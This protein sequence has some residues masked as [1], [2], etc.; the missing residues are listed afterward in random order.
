MAWENRKLGFFSNFCICLRTRLYILY[1]APNTYRQFKRRMDVQ[2]DVHY[3]LVGYMKQK[4]ALVETN[5][6]VQK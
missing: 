5:T 6:Q 2:L 1:L 3:N 4:Q